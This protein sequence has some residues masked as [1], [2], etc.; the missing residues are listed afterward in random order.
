MVI[1]TEDNYSRLMN[2]ADRPSIY[3]GYHTVDYNS[4]TTEQLSK[5]GWKTILELQQKRRAD[6]IN[7]MKE[8]VGQGKVLTDLQEIYVAAIDGRG[9]LLIVHEGFSQPVLMTGERT[10]ETITDA[11][12]PNAIDDIT[13]NI[14]WEILSKK[15]QVI[16]TSQDEIKDLGNIVLKTRY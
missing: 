10:F 3:C 14:A 9:D 11:N 13:N 6:A 15:G 7:D 12:Q 8:A 4:T 16:F 2:V 5:Q 1:G